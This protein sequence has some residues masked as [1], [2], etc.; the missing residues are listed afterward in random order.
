MKLTAGRAAGFIE[1]PDPGLLL[2]LVY[3]PDAGMVRENAKA[4]VRAFLPGADAFSLTTLAGEE[5][6]RDPARLAD[7]MATPPLTGGRRGLHAQDCGDALFPV[8]D[9]FLASPP[10]GG[11]F[12]VLEAGALEKRSKLR[13]RVEDDP[14]AMAIP[15][16]AE[17][18]AALESRIQSLLRAAGLSAPQ[19]ALGRLAGL[20]PPDRIGLRLELEKL[21]LYAASLGVKTLDLAHVEAALGDGGAEDID[22]TVLAAASGEA[23]R[24]E[25]QLSRL[26]AS[27]VAPVAL[28]RAAQRHVLRL[29]EARARMDAENRSA[30]EAM[31]ALRPPVF[32]KQ[33]NAVRAQLRRWSPAGLERALALLLKAEAR[34]KSSSLPAAL[35]GEKALR[36]LCGA[37]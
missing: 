20:L 36:D 1:K 30:D 17:E 2:Y 37:R 11:N 15:C 6:A 22:Q 14:R 8:V 23:A 9:R 33:E 5:L 25:A 7:E 19:P 29:Y 27:G 28:L 4:L 26:R 16:Y 18:G 10:G 12:A 21:A 34:A 13:L 35:I 32:F 3:G 31:K 24:L